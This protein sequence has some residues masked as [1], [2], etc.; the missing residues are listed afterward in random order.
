MFH[1]Q[2]DDIQTYVSYVDLFPEHQAIYVIAYWTFPRGYLS[3][4]FNR[5]KTELF[6]QPIPMSLCFL[7]RRNGPLSTL[8][9]KLKLWPAFILDASLI[10]S[11]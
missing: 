10:L 6:M 2:I 7:S 1:E 11:P 5:L 9:T 3:G 4:F 8:F